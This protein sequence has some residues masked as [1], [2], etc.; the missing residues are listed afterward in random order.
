MI[1][2][3]ILNY[4]D[5]ETTGGLV[6]KIESYNCIQRILIVDNCSTDDSIDKLSKLCSG[7][8]LLRKMKRNG[9]YGYGN[10]HGIRFLKNFDNP[11]YILLA[12]PDVLIEESSLLDLVSFMSSHKNYVIAAP[13]MLNA[14][15]E[16]MES[17]AFRVPTCW[18]YIFSMG[19]LYSKYIHP[20]RYKGITDV[21][22]EYV[23]VD[24]VAGSLFMMDT[25]KFLKYGMYDE[26]MFL[27]CEETVLGLKI[28]Q[29]PYKMAL[30]P[31]SSFV[32]N[33][34][35]SINKSIKS[36]VERHNILLRSKMYA[37]KNHYHASKIQMVVAVVVSLV[38]RIEFRMLAIVKSN[39]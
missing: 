10:N 3:I 5:A 19:V 12:N 38:S 32:H 16:R 34:S 8:V 14:K 31:R 7:K 37:I 24:A 20:T 25:N 33:H 29:S 15:K 6:K 17:T 13:F 18:Q 30:L 28:K 26:R 27:Y 2:V 11:D 35:V 9:G 36:L 23:D 21:D 4:N 39:D 22:Y 1:D